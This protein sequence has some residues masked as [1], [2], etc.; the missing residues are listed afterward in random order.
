MI[1]FRPL[2]NRWVHGLATVDVDVDWAESLWRG[3]VDG[4]VDTE[5]TGRLMM[6]ADR[7]C[8][9]VNDEYF[10][11][12]IVGIGEDDQPRLVTAT[13]PGTADLSAMLGPEHPDRKI[14]LLL[15]FEVSGTPQLELA[16]I[17]RTEVLSAGRLYA[18]P[19]YLGSSL[20]V[21][22]GDAVRLAVIHALG[23]TFR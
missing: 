19:A 20:V 12:D 8:A 5:L 21:G 13:G 10:R 18:F 1:P 2:H 9:Q 15:P 14:V 22:E 17:G 11:F 3:L 6:L 4:T 16:P 7:V 23:P